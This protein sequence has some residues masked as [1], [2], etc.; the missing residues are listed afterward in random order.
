MTKRVYIDFE[1][2]SQANIWKT[3]AYRYAEDPST[4]ILCLAWAINDGPIEGACY[5]TQ[6]QS[7]IGFL[8]NLIKAGA[9][10]HAHNAFFERSIWKF[11]LTPKYGA[12]SIPITQWRCT[13]AKAMAHALPRR[14]EHA[15]QALGGFQ[16]D[17]EGSK[18]M[19][20][21]CISKGIIETDKLNRLLQY[22]KNDVAVERDIDKRLPD[23]SPNEQ[24]VWF[25]DQYINDFGVRIDIDAVRKAIGLIETETK[26]LNEELYLLTGGLVHAG[27]QRDAIKKYL[28]SRGVDLPDL[29][30]ATVKSAIQNSDG[31]NLRILQLRQQLS[32]TSN[33]KYTALAAAVSKDERIRDTV[34]YHGAST[35]RWTGKL[36]QIQNLVKATVYPTEVE[37][38]ILCLK[39]S[40][41]FFSRCYDT[42]PT[43]SGC[44]RGMFIPSSGY[45]MFITDFS[46]IEARVVM[47]LAG[48]EGG[49]QLFREQDADPALPDIYVHM[50]R[51][52]Y[53]KSVLTKQNQKERQLGKQTVLGCGFGMGVTKFI[54][55]CA[56]YE[57]EVA[58]TLADR[59]VTSYRKVFY[60]VPRFW[61]AMEEA[62]KQTV[63]SKKS[64]ECG[65]VRWF[66]DGE[67]LR[68]GLPSGRTLAYHRP[69]VN[70]ENAL[71]FL[72]VNNVTN[73]YGVE[74]TWG[75]ILVEN[76]TQAVARDIMVA[77]M[78][79]LFK[80]KHRVLFTVHDELITEYPT[81]KVTPQQI[82]DIV[83]ETPSWA[84]GCPINA[85][86]KQVRRYQ[87]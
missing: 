86:C 32:L 12:L 23:L 42:L 37:N 27:T 55:T 45:D 43:L 11:C 15:A 28:E 41:D 13:A 39:N 31:S 10:F 47:W 1:S 51:A 49:L 63:L 16:K 77:A 29:T 52:I 64:H 75:G 85:E 6:L 80:Q 59:A 68:L 7:K 84:V 19:R 53:N 54:E 83:R 22:C 3:G 72:A 24:Q 17:M 36:V 8:N 4:E 58:P 44:V 2:R 14:L 21:L 26:K 40:P 79:R 60:R 87:K 50:A 74:R 81:K 70:A 62:A 38:A 33:A 56:K 57:I 69:K 73:K 30:K 67:F 5:G 82:V 18:L 46:A 65:K 9:E 71:T 35:G 34:V 76:A 78:F 61:Y 20:M 48:E 66:M 25:M